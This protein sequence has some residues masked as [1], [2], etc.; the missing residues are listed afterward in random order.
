[1]MDGNKCDVYSNSVTVGSTDFEFSLDFNLETLIQ[2]QGKEAERTTE[3]IVKVRMSPQ[4]AKAFSLLL[5]EQVKQYEASHGGKYSV[6]SDVYVG[7]S[8]D[9]CYRKYSL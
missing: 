6:R 2:E 3:K 8:W 1:M 9:A 4:L 5:E 7:D